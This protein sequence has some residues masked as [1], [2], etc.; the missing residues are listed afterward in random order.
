MLLAK[1]CPHFSLVFAS[2]TS[3]PTAV[4]LTFLS[5]LNDCAM[6]EEPVALDF[7]SLVG[8]VEQREAERQR[9]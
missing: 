1:V 2:G 6:E 3:S 8:E 7:D 4:G 5:R 9:Q